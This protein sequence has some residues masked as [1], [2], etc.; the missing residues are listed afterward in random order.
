MKILNIGLIGFGTVG[1]GVVKILQEKKEMLCQKSNCQF[2]IKLIADKDIDSRRCVKVAQEILTNDANEILDNPEIDVVIELIGGIHPAKEFIVKALSNKKDVITA[3]KALLAAEGRELF[4]VASDNKKDILF[5]ASVCGG[6]PIIKILKESLPVNKIDSLLGIVNGTAN[7]VLSQMEKN[8]WEFARA[9]AQAKADG[10]AEADAS[11]DTQGIDSRHKIAILSR[12]IFDVSIEPKDIFCQ[13]IENIRLEDLRYAREFGYA[14]K[15][16]AI[17]RKFE[18]NSVGIYVYPALIPKDCLLSK[19]N[20][21]FNAVSLNGDTT[22]NLFFYGRGAGM[23]PTASAVVSDLVEISKS[24]VTSHQSPVLK[25]KLKIKKIEDLEKSYYIRFLAIDQPGVLAEIARI[26]GKQ[27]VSI[28]SV[29]QKERREK[30]IVPIVMM[31]HCAKEKNVQK[32]LKEIDKL[33]VVRERLA[34]R[35]E[36]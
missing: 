16:L 21:D 7:Y 28:A 11:L 17:V 8:G 19:V 25:T 6:I 35:I 26:L 4:K 24:P 23:L 14:I 30:E 20:G 34:A 36:E 5:E 27:K 10:I 22:G 33:S 2:V 9:I 13:G 31:T 12:L 18:Q 29:V 1:S 15:L 3:N 32:A